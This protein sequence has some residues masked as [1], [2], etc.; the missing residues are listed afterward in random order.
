MSRLDIG[1]LT[2]I[3]PCSRIFKSS[4]F[5]LLKNLVELLRTNRPFFEELAEVLS[6]SLS[7]FINFS[8][9]FIRVLF[10]YL[11]FY[12]VFLIIIKLFLIEFEFSLTSIRTPLNFTLGKVVLLSI[13]A[14]TTLEKHFNQS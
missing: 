14:K 11:C 4:C 10:R 6:I 2:G 9:Q 13:Q 8:L 1:G 5:Y 12:F 7:R 3:Q